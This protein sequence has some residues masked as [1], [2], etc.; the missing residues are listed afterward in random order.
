MAN[1]MQRPFFSM[2]S[3]IKH[4]TFPVAEMLVLFLPP[5]QRLAN[6]GWYSL[7]HSHF[8]SWCAWVKSQNYP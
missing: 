8:L 1:Q 4:R 6:Q 5:K 3:G 7:Q 2:I